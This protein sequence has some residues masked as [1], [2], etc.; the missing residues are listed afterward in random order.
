MRR[1]LVAC[2][3]GC[4]RLEKVVCLYGRFL[5]VPVECPCPPLSLWEEE[6]AVRY[7][8]DIERCTGITQDIC[9]DGEEFRF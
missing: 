6:E 2:R 4:N 5:F 3:C 8:R 7:V 1:M 9:F